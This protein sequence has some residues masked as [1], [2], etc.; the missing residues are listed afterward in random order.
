MLGL[1]PESSALASGGCALGVVSHRWETV[2]LA[3]KRERQQEEAD[4]E[5]LA[6]PKREHFSG[7]D[8]SGPPK[9]VV[10]CRSARISRADSNA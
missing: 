6:L 7:I 8:Q 1:A 4:R 10:P 2:L 5:R 3:G 9:L